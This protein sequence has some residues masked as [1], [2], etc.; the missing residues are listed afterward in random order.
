MYFSLFA[1]DSRVVY[2]G[3]VGF[4]SLSLDS[5]SGSTLGGGAVLYSTFGSLELFFISGA[6]GVGSLSMFGILVSES[7]IFANHLIALIWESPT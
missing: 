2:I 6:R 5:S 1:A 3:M 4:C 7:K